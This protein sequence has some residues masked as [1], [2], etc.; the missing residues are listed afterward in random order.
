MN[1]TSSGSLSLDKAIVGFVNFKLAGGLTN[2]SVD[3]YE[4][5]LKKWLEYL[6]DKDVNQITIRDITAYL[7]WLRNEYIPQRF[8]GKT[9]TLSPKSLRNIYI[10]LSSFCAWAALEFTIPNPMKD[11]PPPRYKRKPWTP[12]PGKTLKIF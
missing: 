6:G 9:H 2:R 5:I 12:I 1:R 11:V 7:G 3:S 8:N 10:G 4:R